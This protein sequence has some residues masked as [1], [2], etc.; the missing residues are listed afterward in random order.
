M[1]GWPRVGIGRR[2]H[3]HA[4][5]RHRRGSRPEKLQHS[6]SR[7]ILIAV[8]EIAPHIGVD[9]KVRFG[10]P[11]ITGTRVTVAEVVQMIAGGMTTDEIAREY[12]LTAEQVQAAF[13][14]FKVQAR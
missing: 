7:S 2:A 9:P 14:G 12:D 3:P 10:K 1:H 6:L 11:V 5:R 13:P 8:R 4:A